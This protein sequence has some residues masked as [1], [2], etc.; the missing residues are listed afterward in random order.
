MAVKRNSNLELMRIV[1][2]F[3]IVLWHFLIHGNIWYHTFG[4][5]RKTLDLI[6][7]FLF[8]HVNSFVILT[9]Y[10]Q[11]QKNSN[12]KKIIKLNCVAWFYSI[13]L[14]L[15]MILF[16]KLQVTNFEIGKLLIPICSYDTYWFITC[17]ILLYLISP[18]LNIILNQTSQIQLKRIICL[19]LFLFG[20]LPFLTNNTFYNVQNGYS[21]IHFI[22]LYFIGAYLRKYF[23]KNTSK[24]KLMLII[25][26]C[27]ILNCSFYWFGTFFQNANSITVRK[28]SQMLINGFLSYNNPFLILQSI[29]YFLFFT[30]L[31]IK[32]S[33]INKVSSLVLG[34]YLI[35]DFPYVRKWI[36]NA[37][38]F[39]RPT[40]DWNVLFEV[41]IDAL[42]LFIVCC[43]IEFIRNYLWQ[44]V[45]FSKWMQKVVA[46]LKK[47][48]K[49]R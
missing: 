42:F 45:Y 47:K 11:C 31:K 27:I 19:G 46:S 33:Q 32:N 21:L 37:F 5:L 9:G 7:A 41:F 36:Y 23:N 40:Y 2:M 4:A 49:M 38:G 12:I 26:C 43:I 48:K 17:Y 15:G 16:T 25:I 39:D 13:F 6:V 10:F 3:M 29:C 14:L 8:V 44:K 18:L 30:K 24:K 35:S 22:N 20:I 28:I 1:S 34:V